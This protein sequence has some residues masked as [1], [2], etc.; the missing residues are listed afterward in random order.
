VRIA[1]T[2]GAGFVGRHLV[3]HLVDRGYEVVVVARRSPPPHL[4]PPGVRVI[5]ADIADR[6]SLER[7]FEECDAVAHCAGINRE[8]GEQTYARVHLAGTEAVVAA[9]RVAGAHRVVLLSFLRARPDGPTGYHRS[10]WRAE[11]VVRASGLEWTVLKSGVI[12]GRG[13]HLLDHVSR[14]LHTFPVFAL[15][16]LRPRPLRPVAVRDLVTVITAALE[17]DPRLA[18]RTFAVVG[19]ETLSLAEVVRRVARAKSR[20]VVVVRLPVIAHRLLALVAERVMRVPLVS[21]AQVRILAEGVTLP[22][23]AADALPGDLVPRTRLTDDVIRDG[24]PE[25]GGFGRADLRRRA[26]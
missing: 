5:L 16:G 15:V 10:K 4:V 9:A 14:A 24:L 6:E 19:P 13:D 3:R 8:L 1:V 17:G 11:E 23:P 25:P 7:A 21:L 2:G 26:S 22:L 18:S 12:Y 20:R